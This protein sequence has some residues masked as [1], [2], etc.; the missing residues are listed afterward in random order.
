MDAKDVY[1]SLARSFQAYFCFHKFSACCSVW[2]RRWIHYR[3]SFIVT[4][5]LFIAGGG[6]KGPLAF[7]SV[8]LYA[9]NPAFDELYNPNAP[10]AAA[11]TNAYAEISGLPVP[12]DVPPP[13]VL[14]IDG[15]NAIDRNTDVAPVIHKLVTIITQEALN[16][17]RPVFATPYTTLA[18]NML[19]LDLQGSG[20]SANGLKATYY[21]DHTF[22]NVA[23]ERTDSTVN[24]NWM[25]GS[26]AG[27]NSDN[28]TVR[29]TGFV[30][31]RYSET[32]TFYTSTDD[33]VRLY[34]DGK[35]I[36]DNWQNQPATEYS[37][38]I[39]LN[40]GQRYSIK[41]EYYDNTRSASAKL[42][43]SSASQAKAVIDNKSLYTGNTSL[44]Q[45]PNAILT[46]SLSEFDQ[47]IRNALGFGMPNTI[48]IYST[49]PILTAN[50]TTV[51]QQE[52]V[53][54]YRAAIE[55]LSSLVNQM[56]LASQGVTTDTLLQ[57]LA[58]DLYSDGII[59]KKAGTQ[60]IANIYTGILQGDPMAQKIPNTS[61]YIRDIVSLIDE[62]RALIGDS[63]S[64]PFYGNDMVVNLQRA[65]LDSSVVASTPVVTTPDI[66]Y[67]APVGTISN[68]IVASALVGSGPIVI[69]GQQDV[70]ISG[71]HITN[72]SGDCIKIVNGS[73]NIVIENSEIGPCHGQGVRIET[74]N[75]NITIR[76][77]Y[78]H[79]TDAHAV[80]S[81]ESHHIAVDKNVII[82]VWSGYQMMDNFQRL[83][84]LHEQFR[85]KRRRDGSL[86]DRPG[87]RNL[88]YRAGRF[89]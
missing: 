85:Q 76:N 25:T 81:Y 14:V 84:Q 17:G 19:K 64:L 67:S 33:G 70:V 6:V 44:A 89:T 45:V 15:T 63:S 42:S 78:I 7:A 88:Q 40:A 26:P 62:E 73:A 5:Q 65:S 75:S 12:A 35:L 21:N 29:W 30:E 66:G 54:T 80:W 79:D 23:L 34:V 71:L 74:G 59:D 22:S 20:T 31:P 58:L 53:V 37:G 86:G 41:M 9:L 10:L 50:T 8:E 2:R 55:A 4:N 72:P 69:S 24:F 87:P 32:Y 47:T 83:S 52:L 77:N 43:W 48:N 57:R 18:Y 1:F 49:P 68:T 11:T 28:F 16:A 51:A 36:I 82:N 60:A 39:R 46:A 27:V 3:S 61:Y 13:Y 38:T 56:S